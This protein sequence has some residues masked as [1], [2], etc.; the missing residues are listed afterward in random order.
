[1]CNTLS[2]VVEE[3]YQDSIFDSDEEEY[4]PPKLVKR[5]DMIAACFNVAPDYNGDH[6]KAKQLLDELEKK[7][8]ELLVLDEI[9]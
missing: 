2:P 1:M 9:S 3:E 7:E 4:V 6:A 5:E 8:K